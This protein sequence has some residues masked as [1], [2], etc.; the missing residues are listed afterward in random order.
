MIQHS[1]SWEGK[2]GRKEGKKRGWAGPWAL[3][4]GPHIKVVVLVVFATHNKAAGDV[5]FTIRLISLIYIGTLVIYS[6]GGI[7]NCRIIRQLNHQTSGDE[8]TM[9][10]CI[11]RSHEGSI[12]GIGSGSSW[13]VAIGSPSS[14]DI[15]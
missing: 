3:V 2:E 5:Q 11:N 12:G 10:Y 13:E 9:H 6:R 15:F 14:G 8:D 4:M 7:A 1:C